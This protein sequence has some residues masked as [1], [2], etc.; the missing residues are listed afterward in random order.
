VIWT[1]RSRF[2]SSRLSKPLTFLLI[3][4]A[5]SP[6][7]GQ[8][9]LR[10]LSRVN[11]G[12]KRTENLRYADFGPLGNFYADTYLYD[13]VPPSISNTFGA[14]LMQ[15]IEQKKSAVDSW[16]NV[17]IPRL[18]LFTNQEPDRNGWTDVSKVP[19]L[20]VYSSLLG[21]PIVNLPD[22][23]DGSTTFIAGIAYVSL[24]CGQP[25]ITTRTFP[26]VSFNVSCLNCFPFDVNRSVSTDRSY[27]NNRLARVKEFLGYTNTTDRQL[28]AGLLRPQRTII[29]QGYID[30]I[31]S[32]KSPTFNCHV[33]Q[34]L[35]DVEIYCQQNRCRAS[36]MRKSVT[37]KRNENTTSFDMW[38]VRVLRHMSKQNL[39]PD[40]GVDSNASG[41][42]LFLQ[43]ASS[44]P[45]IP[46]IA[47][48]FH[49]VNLS[50][51][52]PE[53]IASK[54]TI[55]LNTYIQIFIAPTAFAG[56]LD[57]G[58]MSIYGPEHTLDNGLLTV[59]NESFW[60]NREL[61]DFP[62]IF[63]MGNNFPYFPF[64]A[65]STTATV[66]S[67]T[68]V[69]KPVIAWAV[70]LIVTCVGLLAIEAVGLFFR[71]RT[72]GPDL[73]DPLMALTINNPDMPLEPPCSYLNV[74]ARVQML[75]REEVRL[76][77]ASAGSEIGRIGFGMVERIH[78]LDKGRL[79]V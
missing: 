26:D 78:P 16:G 50:N 1:L 55:L 46:Y 17:K 6:I 57:T 72:W 31:I 21:L 37:D 33:R 74:A 30:N 43:N 12:T 45:V 34:N 68:L 41:A 48:T 38:G 71:F 15:S 7:G 24:S 63:G 58:N 10:L 47:G 44:L 19:S 8:A 9:S 79:Y 75:G 62:D 64:I 65:A 28:P 36:R 4:W 27:Y 22:T 35:V 66:T 18:E 61:F 23:H 49:T 53:A 11:K 52:T 67:L 20:E 14:A 39:A 2:L 3:F 5:L 29:I 70:I 40:G 56:G 54:M 73:F 76:G 59:A 32:L 13:L 60:R 42:E 25:Y 69:Y 77:D 51:I